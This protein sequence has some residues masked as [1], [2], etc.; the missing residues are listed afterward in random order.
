MLFAVRECHIPGPPGNLAGTQPGVI[1]SLF[2]L[3]FYLF[4]QRLSSHSHFPFFQYLL[5]FYLLSK[6]P[7]RGR[8]EGGRWEPGLAPCVLCLLG[9]QKSCGALAP[10]DCCCRTCRWEQAC[11][12]ETTVSYRCGAYCSFYLHTSHSRTCG[13]ACSLSWNGVQARAGTNAGSRTQP[14]PR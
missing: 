8:G 5:V 7:S 6:G 2:F 13:E 4:T 9:S 1:F 14:S 11:G 12:G 3:L 10:V